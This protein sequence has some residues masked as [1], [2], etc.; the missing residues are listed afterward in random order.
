MIL[1]LRH[2]ELSMLP[3]R[4]E[5]IGEYWFNL[6]VLSYYYLLISTTAAAVANNNNNNYY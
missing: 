2:S 4:Y 3:L 1:S 5:V 6:L